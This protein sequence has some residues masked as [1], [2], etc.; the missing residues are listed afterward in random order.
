[1]PSCVV[2]RRPDRICRL[3]HALRRRGGGV[4]HR[5]SHELHVGCA[6]ALL[7]LV[8]FLYDGAAAAPAVQAAV[9]ARRFLKVVHLAQALAL[10]CRV[11]GVGAADAE[12]SVQQ[13][14]ETAAAETGVAGYLLRIVTEQ[15]AWKKCA[16][17]AGPAARGAAVCRD[18]KRGDRAAAR[19][20]CQRPAS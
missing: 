11:T 20:R 10:A 15:A 17:Q 8:C 14:V 1:M 5:G 19:G 16:I 12:E 6:S 9:S 18:W 13:I 4:D 2:R 3:V 7:D